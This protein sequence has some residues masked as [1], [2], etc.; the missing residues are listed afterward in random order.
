ML[1][2]LS[3]GKLG[4]FGSQ[5]KDNIP[6]QR[7]R[8]MILMGSG[9]F[10]LNPEGPTMS[11]PVPFFHVIAAMP[12]QYV[13]SGFRYETLKCFLDKSEAK[14]YAKQAR[15]ILKVKVII[16]EIVRHP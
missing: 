2:A 15:E 4:L 12:C 11:V 10:R 3:M 14:V 8:R 7:L 6:C 9:S 13:D 5:I 16:K 1:G